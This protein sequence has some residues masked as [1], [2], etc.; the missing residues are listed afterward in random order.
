MWGGAQEMGRPTRQASSRRKEPGK[1]K[2]S[3]GG[4]CSVLTKSYFRDKGNKHKGLADTHVTARAVRSGN[5]RRS[6]PSS[7]LWLGAHRLAKRAKLKGGS[8]LCRCLSCL[9]AFCVSHACVCARPSLLGSGR[10][11]FLLEGR[12]LVGWVCLMRAVSR[13][14]PSC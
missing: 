1:G 6:N 4:A 8:C 3:V 2:G 14:R 5:R 13:S 10:F 12:V 7:S 9:G 11:S